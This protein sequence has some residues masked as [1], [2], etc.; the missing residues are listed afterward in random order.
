LA[1]LV[2]SIEDLIIEDR[3]VEGQAETDGVCWGKIGVGDLGGSLVCLERLVGRG[4]A[5]VANGEF[6]EV[7]VV[8]SLPVNSLDRSRRQ[9]RMTYILW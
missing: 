8:I 9:N 5:L 2:R 6:S 3:K 4:L 7:A 1:S